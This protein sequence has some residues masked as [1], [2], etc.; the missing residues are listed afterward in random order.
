MQTEA[1]LTAA[2]E[3]QMR[4]DIRLSLEIMVRNVKEL[5][6]G[7]VTTLTSTAKKCWCRNGTEYM[8][9]TMI[10]TSKSSFPTAD[11]IAEGAE[12]F[13]FEPTIQNQM[14]FDFLVMILVTSLKNINI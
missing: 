4:R 11:E 12:F 2:L 10:E 7:K 13:S 8:V 9:G 14:G 1:I 3:V 6:F 5:R